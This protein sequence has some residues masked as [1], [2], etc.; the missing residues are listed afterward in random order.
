MANNHK[1]DR[2]YVGRVVDGS[3]CEVG[4]NKTRAF[5]LIIDNTDAD[6]GTIDHFIWLTPKNVKRAEKEFETLGV[7]PVK[8]RSA[9]FLEYEAPRAVAGAEIA[10]GTVVDNYNPD[11]PRVKV[12]WIGRP[13]AASTA[14]L[15]ASV[16][17]L[18][19]GSSAESA[20]VGYSR[21]AGEPAP[22]EMTAALSAGSADD[23]SI[24]F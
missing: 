3:L 1:P 5:Q 15:A 19:G 11:D 22:E 18:F 23:D 17:A 24:P 6:A 2:R 16:A 12:K 14:D 9:H 8:L 13:G 10:Y 4:Q 20:A 7:D 21:D